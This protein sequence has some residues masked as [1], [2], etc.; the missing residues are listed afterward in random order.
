LYFETRSKGDIASL[1][2]WIEIESK[3]NAR[4]GRHPKMTMI[5]QDP[6]TWTIVLGNLALVLVLYRLIRGRRTH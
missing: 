4:L 3:R 6:M 2:L 5:P 1:L